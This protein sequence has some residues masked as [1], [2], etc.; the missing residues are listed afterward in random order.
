MSPL[1]PSPPDPALAAHVDTA[2]ATLA[3]LGARAPAGALLQ[4]SAPDADPS[5][6]LAWFPIDPIHPLDLLLGFVAPV[7]GGRSACRAVGGSTRSAATA[8]CCAVRAHP[9]C[10]SLC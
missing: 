8:A 10:A 5:G 6:E 7:H 4:V 9:G 3:A 2:D 1:V